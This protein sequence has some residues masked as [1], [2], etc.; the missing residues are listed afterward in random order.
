M[1]LEEGK[2]YYGYYASYTYSL[3]GDFT[4]WIEKEFG[5]ID[6]NGNTYKMDIENGDNFIKFSSCRG[7]EKR[8][9]NIFIGEDKGSK[10]LYGYYTLIKPIDCGKLF[11]LKENILEFEKKLVQSE[12]KN[13]SSK[14]L[15]GGKLK[16]GFNKDQDVNFDE[17]KNEII[18]KKVTDEKKNE[19]IGKLYINKGQDVN[20]DEKK[21]EVID[22]KLID[23]KKN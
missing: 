15:K 13:I 21:N 11:L 1:F 2:K 10:I 6:I 5:Y 14:S 17:K 19:A 16:E 20:L 3:N 4:L 8:L 9:I 18:E 23:R 12:C 7:L 22:K